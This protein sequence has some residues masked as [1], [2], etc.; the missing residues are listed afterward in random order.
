MRDKAFLADQPRRQTSYFYEPIDQ[1]REISQLIP[2]SDKQILATWVVT[3]AYSGQSSPWLLTRP[4]PPTDLGSVLSGARH[5]FSR[6]PRASLGGA[7]GTRHPVA[8]APGA[9]GLGSRRQPW[10]QSYTQSPELVWTNRAYKR[11]AGVT[12]LVIPSRTRKH[13][14]L[15]VLFGV[16]LVGTL[17]CLLVFLCLP[18]LFSG[19]GGGSFAAP[20]T[21]VFAS[22]GG[23]SNF[24]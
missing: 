12:L 3:S 2:R 21:L 13:W 1:L 4:R 24:L 23:L 22:H 17:R 19:L 14:V 15:Q 11:G 10:P 18:L 20:P 9:G 5:P 7:S 16:L 6:W 8:Q